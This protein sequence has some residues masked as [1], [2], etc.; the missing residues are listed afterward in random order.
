MTSNIMASYKNWQISAG[1]DY[2]EL[3]EGINK[4]PA[5]IVFETNSFQKLKKSH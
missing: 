5:N 4:Y 3:R 1:L 2:S